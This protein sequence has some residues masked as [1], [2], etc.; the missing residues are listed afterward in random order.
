MT[1][2]IAIQGVALQSSRQSVELLGA[3]LAWYVT[4]A[5]SIIRWRPK[6]TKRQRQRLVV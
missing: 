2:D 5:R 1:R 4:S 3:E 6:A